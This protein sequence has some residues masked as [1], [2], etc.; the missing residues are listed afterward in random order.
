MTQVTGAV[1]TGEGRS[2][3]TLYQCVVVILAS[4]GFACHLYEYTLW[5]RNRSSEPY[6]MTSIEQME[7]MFL[8][9]LLDSPSL[10]SPKSDEG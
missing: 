2:E 8:P 6:K 7:C 1:V 9:K 10:M 4:V 5:R 3:H